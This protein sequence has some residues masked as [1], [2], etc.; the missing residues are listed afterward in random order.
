MKKLFRFGYGRNFGPLSDTEPIYE[1]VFQEVT[2]KYGKTLTPEVRIKLLGSTER[3]SCE[4]CVNDLELNVS[5]DDFIKDFR[6]LSLQRLPN[7]D[8]MPGAERLIRHLHSKNVPICVATSSGEDSVKVK[9]HKHLEVFKLFHHITK[10]TDVKEGKPSPEIFLLAASRFEPK[11]LPENVSFTTCINL[12]CKHFFLLV[13][14]RG[15][16]TERCSRCQFSRHESFNGT[17]VLH[18]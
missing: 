12:F 6:E 9:T 10:G 8:F 16:C 2:T 17:S 7:V 11:A 15:R 3:R 4:I 14:S 13:L 18:L 1:K 5:L